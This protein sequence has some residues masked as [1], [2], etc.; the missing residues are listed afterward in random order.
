MPILPAASPYYPDF[1]YQKLSPSPLAVPHACAIATDR[2][3]DV[4]NGVVGQG[5]EREPAEVVALAG[6]HVLRLPRPRGR[7]KEEVQPL[8]VG[9][10]M[11]GELEPQVLGRD[12]DS[13]LL[14][15]LPRGGG[16]QRL[17]AVG[18]TGH[19][20]V[21][22]IHVA[23]VRPAE[24]Q[25]LPVFDEKDINGG[26]EFEA[27]GLWGGLHFFIKTPYPQQNK[28]PIAGSFAGFKHGYLPRP[29]NTKIIAEPIV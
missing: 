15:C 16:R 4:G 13:R 22:A 10:A 26:D 3:A 9:A 14:L 23:R 2:L 24:H 5:V 19:Q 27:V 28:R 11:H 8:I 20:A 6:L 25:D 29:G 18:V 21:A 12:H 1:I 17:V 7:L